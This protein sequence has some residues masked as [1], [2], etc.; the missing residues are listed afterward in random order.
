MERQGM[1]SEL[2]GELSFKDPL[3]RPRKRWEENI[4]MDLKE[5]R[6]LTSEVDRYD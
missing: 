2:W 1:H 4:R 3:G 6:I 5:P